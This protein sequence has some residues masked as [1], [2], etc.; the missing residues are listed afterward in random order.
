MNK[1]VCNVQHAPQPQ[2]MVSHVMFAD[3]NRLKQNIESTGKVNVTVRGRTKTTVEIDLWHGED[4]FTVA[5][6]PNGAEMFKFVEVNESS[7]FDSGIHTRYY[8]RISKKQ[9]LNELKEYL[10][11]VIRQLDLKIDTVTADINIIGVETLA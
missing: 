10:F 3:V 11:L 1:L 9:N 7:F 6:I 5:H 4:C 2:G 8:F